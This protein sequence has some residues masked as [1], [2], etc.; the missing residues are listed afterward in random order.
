MCVRAYVC[1]FVR[2]M[3]GVYLSFK[4]VFELLKLLHASA[5]T[6]TTQKVGARTLRG[7]QVFAPVNAQNAHEVPAP[8]IGHVVEVGRCVVP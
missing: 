2:V 5:T 4:V 1:T 7:L 6:G 3:C 8:A